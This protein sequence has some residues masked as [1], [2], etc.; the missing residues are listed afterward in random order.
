MIAEDAFC[1]PQGFGD[2]KCY[3]SDCADFRNADNGNR[4]RR[5][6]PI[7]HFHIPDPLPILTGAFV[8]TYAVILAL[9]VIPVF[10]LAVVATEIG[11]RIRRLRL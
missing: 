5:A 7:S 8:G 6:M 10:A 3:D 1:R 4:L 2:T 11:E 9:I